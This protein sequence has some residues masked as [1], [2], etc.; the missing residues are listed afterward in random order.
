MCG[1]V[2]SLVLDCC[3]I[4]PHL[5]NMTLALSHRGPDD[6]GMELLPAG[7]NGHRLGLGHRRLAILDLSPAGHQPMQDPDTGNLI[8]FNGEVY[9]FQ[10]IRRELE[11]Q[12]HR[13]RSQTDTEVILKAYARYG[14]KCLHRLRGMFAFCLWD[15]Q[16]QRLFLA[17]D[18]LGIKP[19]YYYHTSDRFLFSS[20][21]RGLLASGLVPRQLSLAGLDSYL[22]LGAVQDPLT[23]IE[24]VYALPAGHYGIWQDGKFTVH[25]Y[26]KLPTQVNEEWEHRPRRKIVEHLR[27]LL[28]ESIRLRLISDVPL[29]AFLSGGVDS[30]AIASLMTRASPMPPQTVSIVFPEQE[31]SEAPYMRLIAQRFGSVHREIVLTAEELFET[32]PEALA[33]MDQPTFD[34][35]NTY[36]VS[37]YTRQGGL[38]VAL[39]GVGGDELFG[40][41]PSFLWAPRL[42]RLRQWV[43]GPVKYG[44]GA[45]FQQALRHNDRARKLGRWFQDR[46][47]DGC[48][49]FL[50][51]ELFSPGDRRYLV[52]VLNSDVGQ[53]NRAV[54]DESASLDNWNRVSAL[55]LSHYMRNVLLRDTDNMS[56]AHGLEV[57]LPFLDHRLVEFMLSLPGDV[58]VAGNQPK[59]LLVE[60]IGDLPP[61]IMSRRKQGFTLPFSMWLRD[62][63]KEEVETVLLG[64]VGAGAFREVLDQTAVHGTWRRFLSGKGVWVRPWAL[65][66]MQQWCARH[67]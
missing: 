27:E 64:T 23:M 21:V 56:M 4:K 51:R 31:F 45:L 42:E 66:V 19:L 50:V 25:T 54:L 47:L 5:E 14:L 18:R 33:A 24:H 60:A 2:G 52:P 43:P 41:Y 49:Y 6:A 63:L 53:P 22:A 36:I 61:E 8:V 59:A 55:E 26:W 3:P 9:N 12:G 28:E 48:A 34:G 39:S 10:D 46:D 17:R 57:R 20:E 62:Q 35:I 44:V 15:A 37:K 29:G 67:L 1:I 7:N 30:S 65:Y 58:K 40:G 32:L 11:G 16:R 13:F 38:T